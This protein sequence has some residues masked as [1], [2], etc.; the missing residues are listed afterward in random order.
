MTTGQKYRP[1]ISVPCTVAGVYRLHK[2]LGKGSFGQVYA[3]THTES[4]QEYAV[5]VARRS[6]NSS[7][8]HESEVLKQL[9]GFKGFTTVHRFEQDEFYDILLLDLCAMSLQATFNVCHK[10]FIPQ[11]TVKIG[12]EALCRLESLHSIGY[13]HR[14]I[15]PA[16]LLRASACSEQV[17]LVDFGLATPFL[18][19]ETKL[20][21]KYKEGRKFVGTPRFASIGAHLGI[22][23][24]RRDDLEALGYV[25]AYLVKGKLP[26]NHVPEGST[27]EKRANILRSKQSTSIE[28]LCDG[29]PQGF[30]SYMQYCRSLKFE[31]K[32]DYDYLRRVLSGHPLESVRDDRSSKKMNAL[33]GDSAVTPSTTAGTVVL[34]RFSL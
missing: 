3:G 11:V 14:D 4:G 17:Y 20:H 10:I 31:E 8:C 30:C 21:K 5:K 19:T 1:I 6:D 32:P 25:L 24:S 34:G 29:L 7:L 15:T 26:W 2:C 27:E 33:D 28:A 9:Q 16:N 13:T 18:D 23:Q 12:I 22:R